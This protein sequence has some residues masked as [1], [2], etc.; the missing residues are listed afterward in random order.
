MSV[1]TLS[2]SIFNSGWP[3]FTAV[4]LSTYHSITIPSVRPSPISGNLNIYLITSEFYGSFNL[5]KDLLG[6]DHK[7]VFAAR[8]GDN[9][10][11]C[12]YSFRRC[13]EMQ[14]CLI[15][16]QRHYLRTYAEAAGLLADKD[17]PSGL[18]NRGCNGLFVKRI[19]GPK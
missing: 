14:K 10:I 9:H 12:R 16:G 1:T 19:N 3:T 18:F 13:L 2:V 8:V 15:V 11:E 4:P 17:D 7:V 6:G 5:I